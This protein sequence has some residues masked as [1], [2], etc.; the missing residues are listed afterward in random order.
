M[1]EQSLDRLPDT[2]T[3]RAAEAEN[4]LIT[5]AEVGMGRAERQG[6]SCSRTGDS[7]STET[8]G[9]RNRLHGNVLTS[10]SAF[11]IFAVLVV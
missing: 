2:N 7:T 6:T 1:T 11:L 10:N 4:I 9:T 8:Y 3:E 5:N